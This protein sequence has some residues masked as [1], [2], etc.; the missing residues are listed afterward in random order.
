MTDPQEVSARTTN[1]SVE[2]RLRR[3]E[4]IHAV[5]NLKYA[6]TEALDNGYELDDI[7]SLFAPD[8]RWCAKGFG[9]YRGTA[10]IR[11]FFENLS[12]SVT[13]A[14]HFAM[15]PRIEISDDGTE[16]T[17]R[18]Y[19]LCLYRIG[20]DETSSEIPGI[21]IGAY[22]DSLKRT[23]DG[24]LY[25]EMLID[26]HFSGSLWSYLRLNDFLTSEENENE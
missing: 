23:E 3:L 10:E 11:G 25:E 16:A 1:L 19:L 9:D 5:E 18:F 6:Y 22:R 13:F 2:D 21:I 17:S 20:R 14:R 8:A 7:C 4:D 24:W 15:S 26:I 12:Q